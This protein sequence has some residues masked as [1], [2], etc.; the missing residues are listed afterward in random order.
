MIPNTAADPGKPL[1]VGNKI[2][3]LSGSATLIIPENLVYY[4]SKSLVTK[5]G[6][7]AKD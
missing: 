1:K 7:A 6:N 5:W 4:S 2:S 3:Y